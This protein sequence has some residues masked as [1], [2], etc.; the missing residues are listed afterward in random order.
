MRLWMVQ[1]GLLCFLLH[2][3]SSWDGDTEFMAV[4]VQQ[5]WVV[6]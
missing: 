6:R 4:V 1:L 3:S 2:R 5:W